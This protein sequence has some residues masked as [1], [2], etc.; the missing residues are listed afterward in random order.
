[1]HRIHLPKDWPY[2][3]KRALRRSRKRGVVAACFWCGHSYRRGGYNLEA[4]DTHLLVCP[5]FPRRWQA[6]NPRAPTH[7]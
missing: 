4:E 1:M 2:K 6:A 5:E 3:A 7:D